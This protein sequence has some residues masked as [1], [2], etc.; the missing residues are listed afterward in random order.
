M[1]NLIKTVL[2]SGFILFLSNKGFGQ[3]KEINPNVTWKIVFSDEKPLIEGYS[4]IYKFSGQHSFDYTLNIFHG[5]TEG[6]N[7]FIEVYDMQGSVISQ[8]DQASQFETTEM[9]FN[10]EH[11]AT[12]Q[13]KIR[14]GDT[15]PESPAEYKS[16]ISLL[17][18]EK[19]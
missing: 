14:I 2:V 12:Y 19:T 5:K 4:Y 7:V 8:Y 6:A 9:S 10:V 15:T 1:K 18:R 11:N 17:K 3:I 13:V 16:T